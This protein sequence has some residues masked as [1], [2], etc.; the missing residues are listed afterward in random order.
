MNPTSGFLRHI[1]ACNSFSGKGF[2][3]FWLDHRPVGWV[4]P[5]FAQALVQGSERFALESA[6][7]GDPG[8]TSADQPPGDPGGG[9]LRLALAGLAFEARNQWFAELQRELLE[10]G[11]IDRLHGEQFPV[12]DGHGRD[13][14]CLIDRAAAAYFGI[15]AF[16]QHINGFRRDGDEILMW[17]ATRSQDRVNFPGCL[18]NLAAGGLPYGISLHHNLLKECHEEASIPAA[19]ASRAKPVG[20]VSYMAETPKG[21]KPD[22]L[23][24][25]DL[26]LP[27]DF[28]P[29]CNDDEVESFTLM[30]IQ[31]VASLVEGSDR[32]KLNCNLVIIDFLIRH[33]LITP[34]HPEYTRLCE[35]LHRSSV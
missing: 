32:F 2:I 23:Y 5:A 21:C 3:P 13:P 14:L 7:S 15:R 18:D 29:Q 22:T 4:R 26:E 10:R 11:V 12:Y 25:Y 24:C 33:G 20:A 8:Q 27:A 19:I 6:T 9:C 30:P 31:E 16:G 17:I 1:S 35:G 34:E 28:T